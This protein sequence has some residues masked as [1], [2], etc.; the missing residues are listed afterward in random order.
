MSSL[1]S[2]C[3]KVVGKIFVVKILATPSAGE[4]RNKRELWDYK[5]DLWVKDLIGASLPFLHE[6]WQLEKERP[7]AIIVMSSR[8]RHYELLGFV[9][10]HLFD[11]F[12]MFPQGANKRE[13][14]NSTRKL[15]FTIWAI[16]LRLWD[17]T[18]LGWKIS[19]LYFKDIPKTRSG[20]T[21]P[22]HPQ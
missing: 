18:N 21:A 10:F 19:D 13:L 9:S 17:L 2:C 22:V 15:S 1:W 20:Q 12:C 4:R 7:E 11:A 6:W 8:Y 3:G 5:N 16:V 14:K